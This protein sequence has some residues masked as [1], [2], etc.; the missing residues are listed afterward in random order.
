MP[1][2]GAGRRRCPDGGCDRRRLDGGEALVPA[3]H[4]N[5]PAGQ[6]ETMADTAIFDVD[7]TLVDTN[8]VT[9]S[10]GQHPCAAVTV[11]L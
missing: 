8:V 3:P 1:V 5:L 7:G 6:T 10:G 9:V 2:G 11:R 4:D